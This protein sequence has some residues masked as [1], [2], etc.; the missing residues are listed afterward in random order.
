[1][2]ADE[3]DPNPD[4]ESVSVPGGVALARRIGAGTRRAANWAQLVKFGLVGG[5]GYVINL[6][7]FAILTQ[8]LGLYHSLAAAG[9]FCLAISN[10]YLWNRHWTF[11]EASGRS[12]FQAA[13]FFLVSLAGLMINLVILQLLVAVEVGELRAQALAVATAMPVNFV[14]NKLWTFS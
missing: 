3:H 12:S 9:A 11:D 4:V 14:G 7:A 5:S 8:N 1:V 10:N 6:A 13:R 2:P